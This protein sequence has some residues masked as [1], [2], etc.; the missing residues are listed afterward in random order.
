MAI[1]ID[2]LAFFL[3][4]S[5]EN[6][7]KNIFMLVVWGRLKILLEVQGIS[8]ENDC[9]YGASIPSIP[10]KCNSLKETKKI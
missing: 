3:D 4:I 10:R 6:R 1:G 7:C 9:V 8:D 5:T 2:M